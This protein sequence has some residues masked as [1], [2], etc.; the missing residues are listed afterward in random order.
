MVG[1][2]NRG[3]QRQW[4]TSHNIPFAFYVIRL[5]HSRLGIN[6]G[7]SPSAVRNSTATP[8]QT[9]LLGARLDQLV[10][11]QRDALAVMHRDPQ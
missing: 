6:V 9:A 11:A 4:P 8:P 3:D 1:V 10:A 5:A 2:A 7:I